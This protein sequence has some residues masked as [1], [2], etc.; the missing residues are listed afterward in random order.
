MTAVAEVGWA[1]IIYA[2]SDFMFICVSTTTS[3]GS[4]SDGSALSYCSI[5]HAWLNYC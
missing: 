4:S 2:L 1:T 5:W 3:Y